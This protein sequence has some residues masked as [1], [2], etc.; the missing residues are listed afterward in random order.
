MSACQQRLFFILLSLITSKPML[1]KDP[2]KTKAQRPSALCGCPL[3]LAGCVAKLVVLL[4]GGIANTHPESDRQARAGDYAEC[5]LIDLLADSAGPPLNS[6]G[7]Y[8]QCFFASCFVRPCVRPITTA[9]MAR[10][11][12]VKISDHIQDMFP[13]PRRLVAPRSECIGKKCEITEW[14]KP[15]GKTVEETI[16]SY[17]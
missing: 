17:N 2:E 4:T 11:K 15:K 7:V 3:C 6:I 13:G 14:P 12:C 16:G 9:V 10:Q 8:L 1:D 5:V